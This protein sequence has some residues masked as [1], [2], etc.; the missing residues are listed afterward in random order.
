M[1]TPRDKE[2]NATALAATT[3]MWQL[4]SAVEKGKTADSSDVF[5]ESSNRTVLAWLAAEYGISGP[6]GESEQHLL[7]HLQGLADTS[8]PGEF[9]LSGTNGLLLLTAWCVEALQR[10]AFAN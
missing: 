6:R 2:R 7:E 4:F 1:T 10:A 5:S 9:A 3:I 8:S